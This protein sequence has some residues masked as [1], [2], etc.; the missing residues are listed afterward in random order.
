MF[1]V[2]LGFVLLFYSENKNRQDSHL[3]RVAN[4]LLWKENLSELIILFSG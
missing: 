2:G 3:G 1:W 4:K